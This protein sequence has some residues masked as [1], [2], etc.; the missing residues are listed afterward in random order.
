MTDLLPSASWVPNRLKQLAGLD[1]R[2]G[3]NVE[4]DLHG[5]T[6]PSLCRLGFWQAEN[7]L[8][9]LGSSAN[10]NLDLHDGPPLVFFR[11]FPNQRNS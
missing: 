3:A 9:G 10:V 11:C 8:A 2:A 7:G 6:P 4:L 1:G 5:R